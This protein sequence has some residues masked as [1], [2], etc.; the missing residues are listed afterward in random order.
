MEELR[1]Y[2]E[3]Q[4]LHISDFS[5]GYQFMWNRQLRPEYALSEGCLILRE[6]YVGKYYYHYPL[7]L[8]GDGEEELRAI[9]T[10]EADCRDNGTR[11][12]FTNVP[13]SRLFALVERYGADV[14]VTN[15]RRWR[16]YLYRAEDFKTYAGGKYSGQRNHVNKFKKKYPNWEFREYGRADEPALREFLAAYETGQRQKGSYLAK[17]EM[18][19]VYEL[20]PEA[21]RYGL[22]GGILTADGKIV[23]FSVGERCGDM[24]VVHVEKALREYEGA[25]PMI[26]QQFAQKFCGEGAEYLN[27]MD[28]AGD[29]GLRKS[30]LQYLPC[31]IVDKYNLA[32]KRAIDLLSRVPTVFGDRIRLAPVADEDGEAYRRLASSVERNRYWGYDWRTDYDGEGEPSAEWFLSLEREDFK[33]KSELSEGIYL[34]DALVGEAV[35]HRFGYRSEAE[36]GVRL[37]PE[38]EGR[39]FAR[40]AVALLTEYAF[41]HLGLERVEAKCYRENERSEKTLLSAGMRACGSDETYYYF[42]RTPAM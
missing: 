24:V 39:G 37:L 13:K 2:F 38:Y 33:R 1:P 8:T 42:Y 23:A 30:K 10:I 14:Y 40:E 29:A 17:E 31:E 22:F 18:D 4:R 26:A 41:T 35:L 6:R 27:R 7:S 25:Y 3:R 36:I 20:L 21:E 5:L 11:L 32:P 16:D 19:E 9:A 28:D 15:I 34:G 12:H